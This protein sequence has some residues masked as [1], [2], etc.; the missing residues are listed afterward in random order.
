MFN[1]FSSFFLWNDN[2]TRTRNLVV[3]TSSTFRLC[4]EH[5]SYPAGKTGTKIKTLHNIFPWKYLFKNIWPE[6]RTDRTWACGTAPNISTRSWR[7]CF[8]LIS[9]SRTRFGPSP[10]TMKRT[11]SKKFFITMRWSYSVKSR[12]SKQ[13][14]V[15]RNLTNDF[16]LDEYHLHKKRTQ[17]QK[18]LNTMSWCTHTLIGRP[19][20]E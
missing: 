4:Y 9:S 19:Q 2:M 8:S 7:E 11:L 3:G 18:K 13:Q 12:S 15:F 14:H 17:P 10:P 1:L 5:L 6:I 16:F 20:H